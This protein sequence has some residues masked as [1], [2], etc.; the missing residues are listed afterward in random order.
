MHCRS[1]VYLDVGLRSWWSVAQRAV[2]PDV[3]VVPAPP[4]DQDLCLAQG[5]EDF[6]VE[7]LVAETGVETLAVTVLP[8]SSWRN[9]SRLG[10]H[11]GDPRLGA[12][13]QIH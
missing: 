12:V 4:F 13:A 10:T 1:L 9:E 8:R 2:R 7:Q 11:R 3:V 6:A 5:V